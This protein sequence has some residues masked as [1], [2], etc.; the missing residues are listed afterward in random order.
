MT[1][2]I[3]PNGIQDEYTGIFFN[4][5]ESAGLNFRES[6][7]TLAYHWPGGS[8]SWDSGLEVPSDVWSHV[9]LVAEPSG[10]TVYLNGVGVKHNDA[11]NTATFG[12]G[13]IGSYKG[14]DSRNYRG[15]IDEVCIW[16]KSLTQEEIRE[17][18]TW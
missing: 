11:I 13:K 4:D 8:W 10:V 1:A 17:Y 2:W 9:A 18:R 15:Q 5:D 6:N 7:N 3:K 14:W 16:N 12:T